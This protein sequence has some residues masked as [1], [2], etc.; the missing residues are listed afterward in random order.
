MS[1]N[2]ISRRHIYQNGRS[3]PVDPL[4]PVLSTV[5]RDE[6]LEVVGHGDT[7]RLRGA[8]KVM[9]D[10]IR[11]VA[12]RNLDRALEAVDVAVLAC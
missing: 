11:V 1:L 3:I 8:Q 12:K 5:A 9:H 6:V 2:I 7:L 4:Q 10:R